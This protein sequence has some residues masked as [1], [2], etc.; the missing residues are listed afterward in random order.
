MLAIKKSP[1]PD[2]VME[3]FFTYS[4]NTPHRPLSCLVTAP[5][6]TLSSLV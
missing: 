6:V 2:G 1:A 5:H 3:Y 4:P